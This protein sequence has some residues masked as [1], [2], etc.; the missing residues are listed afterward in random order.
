MTTIIDGWEYYTNTHPGNISKQVLQE[1]YLNAY[2]KSYESF[3]NSL[4]VPSPR[5]IKENSGDSTKIKYIID[6]SGDADNINCCE[7]YPVKFLKS[8]FILNK[9]KKIKNDLVNYYKPHGFYVKGPYEIFIENN[10]S[11]NRFCIELCW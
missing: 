8:K 9:Y 10:K 11:T 5:E 2:N 3:I 1:D 6:C 4:L 7:N